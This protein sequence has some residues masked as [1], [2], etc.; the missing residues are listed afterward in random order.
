MEELVTNVSNNNTLHGTYTTQIRDNYIT[1]VDNFAVEE[2]TKEV[3][4]SFYNESPTCE[5]LLNCSDCLGFVYSEWED[6]RLFYDK[7]YWDSAYNIDCRPNDNGIAAI[8]LIG[9]IYLNTWMN[10]NCDVGIWNAPPL[11]IYSFE[12][13]PNTGTFRIR[14]NKRDGLSLVA[15]D[16]TL[17]LTTLSTSLVAAGYGSIQLTDRIVVGDLRRYINGETYRPSFIERAGVV[18]PVRPIWDYPEWFPGMLAPGR[19]QFAFN[20]TGAGDI[21][22]INIAYVHHYRRI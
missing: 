17:N 8:N 1:Y 9:A 18:S 16:A 12:G 14:V 21:S 10:L 20:Y 6:D 19:S 7:Y 2:C 4:K 15:V 3:D 13:L 11:S 5:Q 22:G